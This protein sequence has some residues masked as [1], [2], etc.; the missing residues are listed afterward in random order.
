ML[1]SSTSNDQAATSARG[2]RRDL[3]IYRT[4]NINIYLNYIYICL[5]LYDSNR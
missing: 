2:L 1:A 5:L 4:L 3:C